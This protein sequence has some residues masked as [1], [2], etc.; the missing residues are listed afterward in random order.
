MHHVLHVSGVW[1]AV[2]AHTMAQISFLSFFLT[3]CAARVRHKRRSGKTRNVV[4]SLNA[5]YPIL[6]PSRRC[7]KRDAYE[8]ALASIQ[9]FVIFQNAGYASSRRHTCPWRLSRAFPCPSSAG[10]RG[11]GPPHFSNIRGSPL[12][13][14]SVAFPSTFRWL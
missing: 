4:I 10:L 7:R 5:G 3:G 9:V 11:V 13:K 14:W 6:F 2:A 12:P 1:L 8:N